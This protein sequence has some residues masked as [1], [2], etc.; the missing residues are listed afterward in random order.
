[1]EPRVFVPE[2]FG[3]H[4]QCAE[5]RAVIMLLPQRML[6]GCMAALLCWGQRMPSV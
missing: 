1:M 4:R 5:G 6:H 3:S 2:G